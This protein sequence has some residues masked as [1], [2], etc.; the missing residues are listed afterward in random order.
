M[1]FIYSKLMDIKA[2]PG[3]E[4]FNITAS[5]P[6]YTNPPNTTTYISEI[7]VHNTNTSVSA[8]V[9]LFLVPNVSGSVG[10]ASVAYETVRFS[11]PPYDTIFIGPKYPY[12]L[13]STNDAFFGLATT[14]SVNI[15]LRGGKEA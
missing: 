13:A 4:N 3:S 2:L 8:S 15:L 6:I 10:T 9:A 11:L 5:Q 1:A 14:G 12:I 7:E